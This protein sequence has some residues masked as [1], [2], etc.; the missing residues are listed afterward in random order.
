MTNAAAEMVV[1]TTRVVRRTGQLRKGRPRVYDCSNADASYHGCFRHTLA[2][3]AVVVVG[4]GSGDGGGDG[5]NISDEIED[6]TVFEKR[7]K[8][9]VVIT[10]AA[11][12]VQFVAVV[13]KQ[14]FRSN[15]TCVT[16]AEMAVVQKVVMA[17]CQIWHE[18][19]VVTLQQ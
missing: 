1:N 11:V 7:G 17:V 10:A 12:V 9:N 18:G 2:A 6:G 15:L 13:V 8:Q 3:A 19:G 5:T 14:K 16:V 4:G